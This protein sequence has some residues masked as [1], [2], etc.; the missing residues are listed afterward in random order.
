MPPFLCFTNRAKRGQLR[1]AA[2]RSRAT[3]AR[4]PRA[5]RAK[6]ERERRRGRKPERERS[7]RAVTGGRRSRS[8]RARPE[9]RA[10]G[11]TSEARRDRTPPMAAARSEQAA[12]LW[13][14]RAEPPLSASVGPIWGPLPRLT[15]CPTSPLFA[16]AGRVSGIVLFWQM[17]GGATYTAKGFAQLP[18]CSES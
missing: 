6:R 17:R 7:A 12:A 5:S 11:E 9:R 16:G 10:A 3:K 13:V 15:T 1:A 18:R 4:R 8:G 14:A 2:S